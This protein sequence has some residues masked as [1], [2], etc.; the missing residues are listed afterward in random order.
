MKLYEFILLILSIV[1]LIDYIITSINIYQCK[2]LCDLFGL[3][4]EVEI[5][6]YLE[7]LIILITI[8]IFLYKFIF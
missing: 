4:I 7:V 1:S 8:T 6:R 2:E 5:K 3:R